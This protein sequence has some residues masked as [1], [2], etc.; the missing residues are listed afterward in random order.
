MRS[1]FIQQAQLVSRQ[2]LRRR[3]RE[4][5]EAR[6]ESVCHLDKLLHRN[7]FAVSI[8]AAFACHMVAAVHDAVAGDILG[9]AFIPCCQS[10]PFE[11]GPLGRSNGL[12]DIR[13]SFEAA[14]AEGLPFSVGDG[15][16]DVSWQGSGESQGREH[17]GS[18]KSLDIHY[19]D[20]IAI[21]L[22]WDVKREY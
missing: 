6:T 21:Y 13:A 12:I 20:D 1:L 17:E 18:E 19:G 15:N 5:G 2:H 9:A 11:G 4:S 22:T 3:T 10:G 16:I 8:A 7:P 14:S